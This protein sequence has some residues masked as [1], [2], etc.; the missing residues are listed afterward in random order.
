[1]HLVRRWRNALVALSLALTVLFTGVS[2]ERYGDNLQIALPL[3]GL[4]C[5]LA[6]GGAVEYAGRFT[7]M[8]LTVRASKE[9]AGDAAF[10]RRPNDKRHGFPSGH[11]SA[12]AFGASCPRS[13]LHRE[14][15]TAQG[16]RRGGGG[17]CRGIPHF[18][19][20]A[21]HLAGAGRRG[22]RGRLRETVSRSRDRT[23]A[24]RRDGKADGPHGAKAVFEPE[25]G[26]R[27]PFLPVVG[28]RSRAAASE[29]ACAS[30]A[31]SGPCTGAG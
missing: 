10:N 1:M 27:A 16:G 26:G 28:R 24:D 14:G 3:T 23:P 31:V 20:A 22:D 18:D 21:Q 30:M 6:T 17:L 25:V 15:A 4:A 8:W 9:L 29:T 11:T 13:F 2:P 7:G 19:G 12:A 5:A